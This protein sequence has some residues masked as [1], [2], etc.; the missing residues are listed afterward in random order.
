[1][2]PDGSQRRV[3]LWVY[4]TATKQRIGHATATG[5][6]GKL[7]P[8]FLQLLAELSP[9]VGGPRELAPQVGDAVFW[10]RY[11]TAQAQLA[12]LVIAAQGAMPKNRVY[13][14]RA[15]LEWILALALD[16]RRSVQARMLLSAAL[17]ADA[18]IGSKVHRELAAPFA[19]LFRVEPANSPFARTA[20]P[21]LRVLGLEPLWQQRR[22]ESLAG[23]G[24]VLRAWV[25]RLEGPLS[26]PASGPGASG[27]GSSGLGHPGLGHPGLGR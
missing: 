5:D 8:V 7:G 14:H 20:L 24:E 10:D 16:E 13:G 27:S 4:D 21:V 6:D 25:T 19:E 9:L 3:D 23:G 15:I 22:D 12:A 2:R 26:P 17:A 18:T 11:A 1:M